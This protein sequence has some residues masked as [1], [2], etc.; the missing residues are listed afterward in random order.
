MGGVLRVFGCIILVRGGCME[1]L[2]FVGV[3]NYYNGSYGKR[4]LLLFYFW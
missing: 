1:R 4:C 2:T 3:I